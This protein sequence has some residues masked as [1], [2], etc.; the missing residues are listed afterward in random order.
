MK[1]YKIDLTYWKNTDYEESQTKLT[2]DLRLLH[3]DKYEQDELIILDHTVDYYVGKSKLGLILRNIQT[4][5][6]EEDI[7]NCFI[8]IRSTNPKIAQEMQLLKQISTDPMPM[9]FE[10]IKGDF[11]NKKLLNHPGSKKDLYA[12][13][14]VNPLMISLENVSEKERKLLSE[15]KTFCMYPW[16]HLHAYPTGEAYPCC[17]ADME[18][19]K[20]G[21]CK[22]NT[23]KEIWNSPAQRQL[24]LDMLTETK[25][26]AC[27]MCY[28]KEKSGFFSGRQ[29]ANK[30][31]GHL[32]E[33]VLE[34]KEDGTYEN[35]EM[36]Y[37]DIRFSNLCNLSC[38]SCGHIFSSS[39]YKDQAALAG[40]EWA[41]NNNVLNY[42]G[43]HETDMMDQLMEHLE[44]VEQIY[45]AGGE[46][47]MMD[48]HYVILEE[49]ERRERFDVRLIYNTNFT[50]VKLKNRLV[51]DY[52]KKFKS[53]SV[54]ASLDAMGAR[55][56]Y[57]RKGTKWK[58][59]EEN[60]QQMIEICPQV[61][62]YISPTLSIMNAL[63]IP[64]FHRDWVDK[65]YIKPQDLNV[66]VVQNPD[67]YRV[68]IATQEY[69]DKII[70]K[71]QNHL[72][73]LRPLD[74]L[75]RATS[76][77]ESAIQYLKTDNTHLIEKFWKKTD[78]LD[79]IRNENI[80]DVIPEL[81][82]LR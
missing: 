48:E 54:G 79:S 36:V 38:R 81:G 82:A 9:L 60:R 20:I 76:G 6:N 71:Y 27:S 68:D 77:Y 67:F 16:I 34:T 66:N 18:N 61:D 57:I 29:S 14:S 50:H 44:Y 4:I 25:N 5:I 10:Y 2:N 12:Y 43:R 24:R 58:T 8:M 23:L 80:L 45:F 75:N 31:H 78:Q 56:E 32:I 69:K 63:H 51:F 59:V 42:A 33:R 37:W 41:K 19:G 1:H 55:A 30:H 39:W 74:Q 7:S 13:G 64:D 70:E 72:E 40:P 26:S 17:M 15:S 46:P 22:E 11:E 73:W 52:W 28:E 62:F 35:F 65:G 3:K 47:L 53:V 21:N 49:L